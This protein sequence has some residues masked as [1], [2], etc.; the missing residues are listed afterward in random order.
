MM[1]AREQ[2]ASLQNIH[3]AGENNLE[4]HN[5]SNFFFSNHEQFLIDQYIS[6]IFNLE[7]YL[8]WTVLPLSIIPRLNYGSFSCH[9][10]LP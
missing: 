4:A 3:I 6:P 2:G 9:N 10:G 1:W 7:D 8:Q 5:L